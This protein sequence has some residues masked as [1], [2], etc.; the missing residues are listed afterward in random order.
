MNV[1]NVITIGSLPPPK[2]FRVGS[3]TF[4]LSQLGELEETLTEKQKLLE[5]P[6]L[7]LFRKSI[8]QSYSSSLGVIKE[9]SVHGVSDEHFQFND[10]LSIPHSEDI[11]VEKGA[12]FMIWKFF[13]SEWMFEFSGDNINRFFRCDERFCSMEGGN[14]WVPYH[15]VKLVLLAERKPENFM[16]EFAGPPGAAIFF[17]AEDGEKRCDLIPS[18]IVKMAGF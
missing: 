14:L 9:S 16:E 13:S 12:S 8:V 18:Q 5:P 6:S 4:S 1:S 11:P 15:P 3:E 2:S 10:I 17:T 7:Q